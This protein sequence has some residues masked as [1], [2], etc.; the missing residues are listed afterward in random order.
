MHIMFSVFLYKKCKSDKL[1]VKNAV[2]IAY[3]TL[4]YDNKL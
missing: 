3:L 2:K 4:K 1:E